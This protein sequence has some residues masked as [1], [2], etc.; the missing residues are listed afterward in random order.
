MRVVNRHLKG[1]VAWNKDEKSFDC[2]IHGSRFTCK[3]EVVNG[4]AKMG[5]EAK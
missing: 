4:P 5:L 3:G 2:P 1:I